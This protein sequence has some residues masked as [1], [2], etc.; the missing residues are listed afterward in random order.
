MIEVNLLPGAKRKRR[1]RKARRPSFNFDLA[2]KLGDMDAWVP[3]MIA[4]WVV[5]IGAGA[6]LYLGA[7]AEQRELAIEIEAAVADSTRYAGIIANVERLRARRDTIVEKIGI[8]RELDSD[9]YIW[10]HVM[11]E[12][13]RALPDYTWISGLSQINTEGPSEL[14][15]FRIQG[16]TGTTFAL[17]RFMTNLEASPFIHGITLGSQELVRRRG[18]LVYFFVLDAAYEEPP[19]DIL[20]WDRLFRAEGLDGFA[21]N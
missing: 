14:P 9:R 21:A 6:W 12:V 7:K 8:I 5:G 1:R 11:D 3:F 4:G 17:T 20:E 10:P 18:E 19:S 15:S 16:Y 2:S 13:S